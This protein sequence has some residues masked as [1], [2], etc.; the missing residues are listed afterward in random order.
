MLDPDLITPAFLQQEIDVFHHFF[1][2]FL[3]PV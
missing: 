1:V 2:A 3:E